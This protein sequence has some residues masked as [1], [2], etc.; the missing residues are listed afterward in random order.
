MGRRRLVF[1][2]Q[3]KSDFRNLRA[4]KSDEGFART[5]ADFRKQSLTLKR[6]PGRG[7]PFNP[8]HESDDT[9]ALVRHIAEK[10]KTRELRELVGDGWIA[11]YAVTATHVY[12]LA[13]RDQRAAGYSFN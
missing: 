13:V 8:R 5:W 7:R 10:L 9:R 11:L 2:A 6:L 12:F 3:L 4:F 1:T